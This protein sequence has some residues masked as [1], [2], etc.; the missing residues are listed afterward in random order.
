MLPASPFLPF[1]YLLKINSLAWC[2]AAFIPLSSAAAAK[3]EVK[4]AKAPGVVE[5]IC[6][7]E[8]EKKADDAGKAKADKASAK[9]DK[10]NAKDKKAKPTGKDH[11]KQ[12]A[13]LAKLLK[14]IQAGGDINAVDKNQKT[15]LMHAAALGNRTTVCWLVAK[16]ADVTLTSKDGKTAA[17]YAHDPRIGELLEACAKEKEP[18]SEEERYYYTAV[19]RQST[20]ETL[21]DVPC[22]PEIASISECALRLRAGADPKI[23]L[24]KIFSYRGKY[25]AEKL[26]YILRQGYDVKNIQTDGYISPNDFRSVPGETLRLMLALGFQPD[27]NNAQP[28]EE[29]MLAQKSGDL[30]TARRL[31]T[32]HADLEKHADWR[33]KMPDLSPSNFPAL[34]AAIDRHDAEGVRALLAAGAPLEAKNST[35]EYTPLLYAICMTMRIMGDDAA[36]IALIDMGSAIGSPIQYGGSLFAIRKDG[37][38]KVPPAQPMASLDFEKFGNV[39]EIVDILLDAG[40]DVTA[41]SRHGNS[42]SPLILALDRLSLAVA[43]NSFSDQ[44]MPVEAIADVIKSLIKA[45]SPVPEDALLRLPMGLRDGMAPDVCASVAE[46]L[47]KAGADPKATNDRGCTALMTAGSYSPALTKKLLKAGV[48]PKAAMTDGWTALHS[49]QTPE[50]ASL[51][52][53]AGADVNAI[54]SFKDRGT[55]LQNVLKMS[56]YPKIEDHVSLLLDAKATVASG[57][58][59]ALARRSTREVSIRSFEEIAKRL[60]PAGADVNLCWEGNFPLKSLLAAGA[61]LS[62]FQG[63]ATA[64]LAKRPFDAE[65]LVKAGADINAQDPEG[66]T[67]LVTAS[68]NKDAQQIRTLLKLGAK[69]DVPDKEGKT[70]MKHMMS[71]DKIL[72]A[73]VKAEA[74]LP[75]TPEVLRKVLE[76]CSSR[77]LNANEC[78][79][80]EAFTK[81]FIAKLGKVPADSLLY[82]NSDREYQHHNEACCTLIT[83]VASMLL[84]AG[85][86][87][88]AT[89]A[90]GRTTLIS[91]YLCKPEIARRLIEAGADAKAKMKD[92]LT[93]LHYAYYPE[94]L[95]LLIKAGADIHAPAKAYVTYR[96]ESGLTPLRF[97]LK[98]SYSFPEEKCQ[99]LISGF[100]Q[101]G[102][103]VKGDDWDAFTDAARTTPLYD[104]T[105]IELLRKAGADPNARDSQGSTCLIINLFLTTSNDFDKIG[106]DIN[107][108][109]NEGNTALMYLPQLGLPA[110][111]FAS[112]VSTFQKLGAKTD[113]RNKQGQTLY[114]QV[115]QKYPRYVLSLEKLGIKE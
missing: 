103:K 9:A 7:V 72:L 96:T 97:L 3:P 112:M 31:L 66:R 94:T 86:D 104:A 98:C 105:C 78:Q 53:K 21:A 44:K 51:L 1:R 73:Y 92:G 114:Q 83:N 29:L 91:C 40:A 32:E 39:A 43:I 42:A 20:P 69:M 102:A 23:M 45:K 24:R 101:A 57:S 79:I 6:P 67:P 13:S 65:E 84:D 4:A 36:V 17:A 14:A 5:M 33:V 52:I 16:G 111:S 90:A 56:K 55:P 12:T 47:L 60:V 46:A 38:I 113:I 15:A 106:V 2:A 49:A 50:I 100:I 75:V 37:L 85:A 89:D 115:K 62:D 27:M 108:Q 25:S 95:E 58:L 77:E 64:L 82:F 34:H 74:E 59:Q 26:A 11:A 81:K 8:K 80:L 54:S 63:G 109:D 41:S 99:K 87:P 61:K 110:S 93:A 107:A 71:Y 22:L 10:A 70:P 28:I 30:V 18:L 76:L 88:K 68:R 48:N 19:T 35:D